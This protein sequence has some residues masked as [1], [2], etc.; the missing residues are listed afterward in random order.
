MTRLPTVDIKTLFEAGIQFGHTKSR[1]NPKMAPYIYG[2]SDKLH[3]I[4]LNYTSSFLQMAMKKIYDVAKSNGKILFL[5]TKTQAAESVKDCATKCG[6][7]Y[8]NHRWLGGML[9]NWNTV[10]TSIKTLDK[11]E[12]LLEDEN[13]REIYTKKE[14][15]EFT[16]K[17]DKLLRFIGGIREMNGRPDLMV[18][19]DTQKESI[20]IKEAVKLGVPIIAIVDTNC[21]P[22][23]ITIPIPGNDDGIKSIKLFCNFF[24]DAALVGMED[25][26][27][28]SG[29]DVGEI[30][31]I[32]T[33]SKSVV[34][35]NKNHKV[36]PL[37]VEEI[38][39]DQNINSE[40]IVNKAQKMVSVKQP[41]KAQKKTT[42]SAA[43]TQLEGKAAKTIA[44]SSKESK[45]K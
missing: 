3:V 24:A 14:L 12:Q 17:Q 13:Q 38:T 6:Q 10:K 25:S 32:Q 44:A 15:L 42:A 9:T 20:A 16:R 45:K 33:K 35:F 21:D 41:L 8:V 37:I 27:A 30:E 22:D 2:I 19:I 36:T 18:V 26:L 43:P 1:W 39:M 29:I 11:I 5:G 7:F 40:T 31:E 34:K 23:N 28:E 4:N